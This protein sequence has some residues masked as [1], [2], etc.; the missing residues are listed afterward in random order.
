MDRNT[1]KSNERNVLV[2]KMSSA[3]RL[4]MIWREAEV[5]D[6][7]ARLE[8]FLPNQPTGIEGTLFLSM[9]PSIES[10]GHQ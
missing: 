2:R 4:S 10:R 7:E 3:V 8:A 6:A 9:G 5:R 1:Q